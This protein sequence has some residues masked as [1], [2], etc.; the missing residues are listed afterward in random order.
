MVGWHHCLNGHEFLSKLWEM[1][2]EREAW[3][4][5]VHGV[6]ESD[7]VEQLSNNHHHW[8]GS[9]MLHGMA[10]KKKSGTRHNLSG[11]WTLANSILVAVGTGGRES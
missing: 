2:K 6:A 4:A 5:A 9:H 10:K 1:V 8:L 3:R 11:F 7:S